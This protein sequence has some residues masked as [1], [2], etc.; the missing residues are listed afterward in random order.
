MEG[1]WHP[2]CLPQVPLLGLL[3]S[4]LL[5]CSVHPPTLH[6]P[7]SI[8]HPQT[9]ILHPPPP[10]A[11]EYHLSDCAKYF[12]DNVERLGQHSYIPTTQVASRQGRQASLSQ[13]ILHTRVRTSGIVEVKFHIKVTIQLTLHLLPLLILI[14]EISIFP[15]HDIPCPRR[16]RAAKREK[17][18]A[19]SV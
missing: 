12:L 19:V 10:R 17:E 9:S 16:R 4:Y 8:L 2:G 18:V 15:G 14:F 7:S 6:P 13:D 11:H 3:C 1:L 5:L